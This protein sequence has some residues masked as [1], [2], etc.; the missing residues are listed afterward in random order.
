MPQKVNGRLALH[1]SAP[2]HPSFDMQPAEQLQTE[3]TAS[4]I[5]LSG[6]GNVPHV[7]AF[8]NEF[9]HSRGPDTKK[10]GRTR[11]KGSALQSAQRK[12]EENEKEN[13]KKLF[14]FTESD[15]VSQNL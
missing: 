11:G 9:N 5:Q 13:E 2:G 14:P 6:F 7:L 3:L 4:R 8:C 1:H 15:T 10:A 12:V